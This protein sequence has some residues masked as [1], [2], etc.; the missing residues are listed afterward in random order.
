[1][2]EDLVKLA[3]HL[4]SKGFVK[5]ADYLD[6][7]IKQSSTFELGINTD[8]GVKIINAL[9]SAI[10]TEHGPKSYV[11]FKAENQD[12]TIE[13]SSD[14]K[15]LTLMPM[16]CGIDSY[17][18]V[19]SIREKAREEA[20]APRDFDS[21][22]VVRLLAAEHRDLL[23]SSFHVNAIQEINNHFGIDI[24]DGIII[25]ST[26]N[27]DPSV[28]IEYRSKTSMK[29]ALMGSEGGSDWYPTRLYTEDS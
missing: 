13:L 2:I 6:R 15:T 24:S 14:G 9:E 22:E 25:P 19:H 4:D 17:E 5:E 12:G 29:D 7:I 16:S 11:E 27:G 21:P 8:A 23:S 18:E 3:N 26:R 28:K 10:R 20:G 1:M